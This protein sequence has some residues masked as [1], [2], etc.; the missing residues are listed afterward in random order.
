MTWENPTAAHLKEREK[1]KA[2]LWKAC[3]PDC[4]KQKTQKVALKM[5]KNNFI[6]QCWQI[7]FRQEPACMSDNTFF[8]QIQS[9]QADRF[10]QWNV[11][12]H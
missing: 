7:V 3:F 10:S 2:C 11:R 6:S 12:N 8:K 5:D 9:S 1:K 4:E